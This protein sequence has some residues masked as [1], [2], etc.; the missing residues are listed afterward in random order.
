[1]KTKII[2]KTLA[3]S[4]LLATACN[5][6]EIVND[7]NTDKKGFALP[8]TVNVTREGD[9]AT[10]ATYNESTRKLSFSA[11][12]KLFV[13]GSD[14]KA[15]DFAGLL[16]WQSEGTFSG[17]IMTE[18][19][20]DGTAEELLSSATDGAEA[21]LIPAGYKSYEYLE[22][23]DEITPSAGYYCH[24]DNAFA[25]TKAAAVEQFSFELAE[26]YSSGFTLSPQNA[27]VSFT[28]SGLTANKEVAVSFNPIEYVVISKNV[29]TSAEGVATFA[30]RPE[31]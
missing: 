2:L 7:E 29:T 15:G 13:A 3:M 10:K 27:I 11:G 14:N 8:V 28:I 30:L 1:M 18:N 5:K 24:E 19:E 22:L 20:Y 16:A 23:D 26:T 6:N 25:L 17:T 12:D 4:M 9:D 31:C 21:L